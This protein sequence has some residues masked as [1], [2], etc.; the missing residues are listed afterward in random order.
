MLRIPPIGNHPV[1][2]AS[3]MRRRAR[4][5]SGTEMPRNATR[6]EVLSIQEC[7]LTRR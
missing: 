2:A 4:K 7:C 1:S 3:R 5:T 6:E